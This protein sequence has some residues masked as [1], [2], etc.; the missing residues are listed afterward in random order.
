MACAKHRKERSP[1]FCAHKLWKRAK[2]ATTVQ[3]GDNYVSQ[4][5]VF[6]RKVRIRGGKTCVMLMGVP[7]DHRLQYVLSI[8]SLLRLLTSQ[9]Y[10]PFEIPKDTRIYSKFLKTQTE[11]QLTR[12]LTM[13]CE[14]SR[15][16]VTKLPA[17]PA[18]N[19]SS[20]F[21]I[22]DFAKTLEVHRK[23]E[24]NCEVTVQE[25]RNR[26]GVIQSVPGDLASQIFT[27]FG[28]WRWWGLQPHAPAAFTPRNVPGTHFH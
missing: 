1:D 8:V 3:C 12:K 25:S 5:Y 20:S 9:Q 14:F 4:Q 11:I 16:Y 21:K 26:P 23:R 7:G 24:L 13:K 27:I 19:T 18:S 17:N 15:K 6:Q 10:S 28:T 2:F 22:T